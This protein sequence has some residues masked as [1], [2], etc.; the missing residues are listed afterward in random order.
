MPQ[1]SLFARFRNR[2]A[3]EHRCVPPDQLSHWAPVPSSY[4]RGGDA[5]VCPECGQCHVRAYRQFDV[6]ADMRSSVPL[7]NAARPS[8]VLV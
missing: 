2:F 1:N 5:Y 4:A 6:P 7:I 3:A 8:F